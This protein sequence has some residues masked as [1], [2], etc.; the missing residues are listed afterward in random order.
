MTDS[1]KPGWHNPSASP[2][3]LQKGRL[4]YEELERRLHELESLCADVFVAGAELGLPQALLNR[5]WV[6]AGKGEAP[7]AFSAEPETANEV[8]ARPHEVH[9]EVPR[10]PLPTIKGGKVVLVVDDDPL[11]L[12]M[13]T[14]ILS[15]DGYEIVSASSGKEALA[16]LDAR[17][18]I[19][20]LVTDVSMP[21]MTGP[22]LATRVRERH[23]NLPVLFETGFSDLLF[24]DRPELDERSAFVEKPFTSRGLLEAA[25]LVLFG[26]LSPSARD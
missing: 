21:E 17:G 1:A 16:A 4:T 2:D 26:G 15:R 19:D 9:Q 5:L 18:A 25:R 8:A 10:A 6:V 11:M 20:L 12:Q 7:R 13:I 14:K 22:Q 24:E 3:T 23:P